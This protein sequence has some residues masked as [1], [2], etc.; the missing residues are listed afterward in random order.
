L[1]LL[2]CL[3]LCLQFRNLQRLC[4]RVLRPLL[5]LLQLAELGL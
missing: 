2:L 4:L 3:D 1:Y 5:R